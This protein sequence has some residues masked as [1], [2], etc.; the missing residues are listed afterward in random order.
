MKLAALL[1]VGVLVALPWIVSSYAVTV[2][3]FSRV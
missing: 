1:A 2:L 3:I